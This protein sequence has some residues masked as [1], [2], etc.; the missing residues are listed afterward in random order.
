[1]L[2]DQRVV[3]EINNTQH[4]KTVDGQQFLNLKSQ[5]RQ[6]VLESNGYK[7]YNIRVDD[8]ASSNFSMLQ[9]IYSIVDSTRNLPKIK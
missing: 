9:D 4:Y 3:V 8:Y 1:V 6:R 5:F 2:I 7:Y